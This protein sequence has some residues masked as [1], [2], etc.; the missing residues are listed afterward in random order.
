MISGLVVWYKFV[1]FCSRVSSVNQIQVKLGGLQFSDER[2]LG[3]AVE[4]GLDVDLRQLPDATATRWSTRVSLG[5]D[6]GVLR[7]HICTTA[8]K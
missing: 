7:D 8:L 1:I 2:L 3:I 6:P 5:T 4:G